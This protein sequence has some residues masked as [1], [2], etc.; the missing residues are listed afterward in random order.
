[1]MITSQKLFDR[2]VIIVKCHFSIKRLSSD[3][4]DWCSGV[5]HISPGQH[6]YLF[7]EPRA[8]S[9]FSDFPECGDSW[10]HFYSYTNFFVTP[11]FLVKGVV[12]DPLCFIC[13]ACLSAFFP[14]IFTGNFLWRM[15]LLLIPWQEEATKFSL[16]YMLL[17]E[18]LGVTTELFLFKQKGRIILV[19]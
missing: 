8:L 17:A 14:Q 9:R 16:Y 3:Y 5:L 4:W 15:N 11:E 6:H 18:K 1:M 10:L 2:L 12:W 7:F 19:S 13:S